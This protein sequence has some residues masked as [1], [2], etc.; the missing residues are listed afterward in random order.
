VVDA[1]GATAADWFQ[2]AGTLVAALIGVGALW[3]VLRVER[4][5]RYKSTLDAALSD[6]M[7]ASGEYSDAI[8]S[9]LRLI[10]VNADKWWEAP[11]P[12]HARL[13]TL[14][15]V[16]VMVGS[17]PEDQLVLQQLA[18]G[19]F[20][21]SRI[22]YDWLEGHLGELVGSIR[23]WRVSGSTTELYATLDKFDR[24]LLEFGEGRT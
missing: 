21:V 4:R 18:T 11:A 12:S 23:K 13:Q 20:N 5:D 10:N 17:K 9:W 22:R 7:R 16:A 24:A 14:V 2:I 19:T 1:S 6:V 8:S 3:I 15:D